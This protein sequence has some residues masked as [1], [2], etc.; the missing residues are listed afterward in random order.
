MPVKPAAA[1]ALLKVVSVP[2]VATVSTMLLF[3]VFEALALFLGIEILAE[4]SRK[5]MGTKGGRVP[6]L[7]KEQERD[8]RGVRRGTAG[9]RRFRC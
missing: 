3:A 8:L 6:R 2:C 5:K 4:R 7:L 1:M 9:L